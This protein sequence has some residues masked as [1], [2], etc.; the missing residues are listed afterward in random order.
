[1]RREVKEETGIEIKNISYFG[2]QPWPFPDLLM[3]AFIAEYD[4]G[5]I[6]IDEEEIMDAK[7]F[8]VDNLPDLPSSI[9]NAR[10]LID[11]F[12]QKN[13]GRTV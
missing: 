11:W 9:S 6:T 10:Q 1:L 7:W 13:V 3:I 2:S 8:A 12:I 5:E 4:K